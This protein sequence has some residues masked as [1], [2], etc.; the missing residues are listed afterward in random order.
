MQSTIP[1]AEVAAVLQARYVAVAVDADDPD[2]EAM[3]LA[4]EIEN[5]M[6]LPLVVAA[7]PDLAYL[8]GFSG[9]VTRAQFLE[10]V[11]RNA[12]R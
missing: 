11:T 10:F 9:A 3:K 1:D 8:D 2:P 12:S 4:L 7:T 6:M 5:A